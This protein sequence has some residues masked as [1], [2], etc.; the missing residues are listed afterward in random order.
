MTAQVYDDRN[1]SLGEGPLWHPER[2]QLF[3]FDINNKKLLSRS[4]GQPL[5][6]VFD[7][8]VSAA[9]WISHD[10]LL[11]ASETE[12]FVFHLITGERRHVC[13]LEAENPV[14]RSNDGRA[15][16]WG[17]FW[18]GTM[19]KKAEKG[20]GAIY[21]FYRGKLT[22][23]YSDITISNSICF[24]PDRR[25]AYYTDTVT[26]KILRQALDDEGWPAGDPELFIDLNGDGLNPDGSVV[27]AEGCLWSAQW[28]S[29]RVARYSPDGVY[30]FAEIFPANHTSCPAFGGSDLTRL[31]V[32]SAT[33]GMVAPST[34]QGRTYCTEVRA[35]GQ[36][37]HRVIL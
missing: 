17:G 12:F 11:I 16:P 32:T 31:F 15:D 8:H 33:E 18:I 35:K 2:E 36:T 5:E 13:D 20:A 23:L 24:S 4:E 26:R 28:G 34:D 22:Q 1:C 7:Q 21:R 3:W 27:D 6:W 9:G 14:T 19:G 30:L 25:F 10:E 29:S 37:E